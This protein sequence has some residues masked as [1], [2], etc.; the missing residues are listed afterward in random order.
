MTFNEFVQNIPG[1]KHNNP[2]RFSWNTSRRKS[3]TVLHTMHS[4]VP[5]NA[6]LGTQASKSRRPCR[7]RASGNREPRPARPGC[8]IASIYVQVILRNGIC[9]GK[10]APRKICRLLIWTWP[11]GFTL[12]GFIDSRLWHQFE[13]YYHPGWALHYFC[14]SNVQAAGW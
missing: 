2:A 7:C 13:L 10:P 1:K 14:P 4:Q 3:R 12:T 9:I 8:K 5:A 11:I 6:W